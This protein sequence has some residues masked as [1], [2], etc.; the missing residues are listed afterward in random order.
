[1]L[2][3]RSRLKTGVTDLYFNVHF[4]L[5]ATMDLIIFLVDPSIIVL[6]RNYAYFVEK[7]SHFAMA[8]LGRR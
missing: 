8:T 2:E 5:N 4:T 7:I 3:I 6:K 1:M